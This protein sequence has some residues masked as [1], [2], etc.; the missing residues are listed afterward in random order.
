MQAGT[1]L[2]ALQEMGGWSSVE[3]VSHCAHLAAE[4]LVDYAEN[5]TRAGGNG[6]ST[7]LSTARGWEGVRATVTV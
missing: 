5:I 4:H 1:P 6:Q 3:M 7:K 2:Y